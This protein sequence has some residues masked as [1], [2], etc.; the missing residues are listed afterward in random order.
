MVSHAEDLAQKTGLNPSMIWTFQDEDHMG[1]AQLVAMSS[2]GSTIPAT[3]LE[4]WC[5]QWFERNA[6]R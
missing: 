1:L 2:H 3:V 4:K 5:L 6:P